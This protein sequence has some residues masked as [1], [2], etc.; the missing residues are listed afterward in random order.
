MWTDQN[1][2]NRWTIRFTHLVVGHVQLRDIIY[3]QIN[4]SYE[5]ISFDLSNARFMF[6]NAKL[7]G[8][9]YFLIRM[10]AYNIY[11]IDPLR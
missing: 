4:I 8:V 2:K 11:K 10:K 3:M 1:V 5:N 9:Q 6:V 7:I